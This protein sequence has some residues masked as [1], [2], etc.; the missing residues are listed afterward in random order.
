[1]TRSFSQFCTVTLVTLGLFVATGSPTDARASSCP[2]W[3]GDWANSLER[4]TLAPPEKLKKKACGKGLKLFGKAPPKDKIQHC[5]NKKANLATG[6][7]L[8][9]YDDGRIEQG[10]LAKGIPM[11][12]A[13]MRT[14]RRTDQLTRVGTRTGTQHIWAKDGTLMSLKK[15]QSGKLIGVPLFWK[16]D[17]KLDLDQSMESAHSLDTCAAW[18]TIAKRFP[19][20]PDRHKVAVRAGLA[21]HTLFGP[22]GRKMIWSADKYRGSVSLDYRAPGEKYALFRTARLNCGVQPELCRKNSMIFP[23]LQ[24]EASSRPGFVPSLVMDA[25]NAGDLL[26]GI[27]AAI[28]FSTAT[29]T[30]RYQARDRAYRSLK[31]STEPCEI[32]EIQDGLR[33]GLWL[34]VKQCHWQERNQHFEA[35]C[36]SWPSH[37]K[38]CHQGGKGGLF[39][40]YKSLQSAEFLEQIEVLLKGTGASVVTYSGP[41]DPLPGGPSEV[42][43]EAETIK[44]VWSEL[45]RAKSEKV[46]TFVKQ[47]MKK[48]DACLPGIEKRAGGRPYVYLRVKPLR[49]PDLKPEYTML[50]WGECTAS[51]SSGQSLF[52]NKLQPKS[53]T[54]DP[55]VVALQGDFEK[56]VEFKGRQDR[57]FPVHSGCLNRVISAR[58]MLRPNRSH[59][60]LFKAMADR[61]NGG[62]SAFCD[63]FKAYVDLIEYTLVARNDQDPMSD[64]T[65][66]LKVEFKNE[67]AYVNREENEAKRQCATNDPPFVS[68][69]NAKSPRTPSKILESGMKICMNK[70]A[71]PDDRIAGCLAVVT[72]KKDGAGSGD[73]GYPSGPS[74][75]PRELATACDLGNSFACDFALDMMPASS[76]H[77]DSLEGKAC[78]KWK[79]WCPRKS[80][81]S[82][83]SPC[84]AC[85]SQSRD[86]CCMSKVGNNDCTWG[87]GGQTMR[88]HFSA[89]QKQA[90]RDCAQDCR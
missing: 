71:K 15:Y 39:G 76:K 42:V 18:A 50:G 36:D 85:R 46:A 84:A 17:G 13:S 41:S 83:M 53:G 44:R 29:E 22:T 45:S 32:G 52:G 4:P 90:N 78:E 8:R 51:G 55:S 89:C 54:Q 58:E 35:G 59:I 61:C 88:Q 10:S 81:Y 5:Y 62:D 64:C 40:L 74:S 77:R 49:W 16:P 19:N 80:R 67:T 28:P 2:D 48:I 87:A 70:D 21:K 24:F 68:H 86:S 63:H 72:L 57:A 11:M 60:A 30:Y 7:Y 25:I 82:G 12:S 65:A 34:K 6:P 66:P 73:L 27:Y 56:C 33:V 9:W 47:T 26:D 43:P 75:V 20:L 1:M 31:A 79:H 23:P 38:K 3:A 69:F 14:W 37:P